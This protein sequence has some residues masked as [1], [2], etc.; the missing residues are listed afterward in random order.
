MAGLKLD[1]LSLRLIHSCIWNAGSIIELIRDAVEIALWDNRT[2]VCPLDFAQAYYNLT[3]CLPHYNVFV[4]EQ[5]D[6]LPS[7]LAKL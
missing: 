7:G 1:D 4:E 2:E 3:E 6:A 5:W